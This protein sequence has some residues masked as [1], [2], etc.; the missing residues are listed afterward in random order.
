MMD[1]MQECS[2]CR[3]KVLK[4]EMFLM[5]GKDKNGKEIWVCYACWN[6]IA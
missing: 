5:P 2:R 6:M 4:K 1:G 3:K